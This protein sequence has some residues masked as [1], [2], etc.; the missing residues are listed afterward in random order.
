MAMVPFRWV[1]WCLQCTTATGLYGWLF[2]WG[3]L[4]LCL[5]LGPGPD[6]E[7]V[8]VWR[9]GDLYLTRPETD[10]ERD[11]REEARAEELFCLHEMNRYTEW[12]Y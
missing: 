4:C 10:Q 6:D 2:L 9:C 5:G 7:E 8:E 3:G 1:P 12:A 11:D